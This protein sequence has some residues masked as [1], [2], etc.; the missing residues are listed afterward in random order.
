MQFH[1][2]EI[3]LLYNPETSTGRQTRAIAKTINSNVNELNVLREKLGPTYWKEVVNLLGLEPKEMMDRSHPDYQNLVAGKSFTM[4]GYLD[5]L[6]HFPH[7]IKGPIVIFNGRAVLCQTPTDI[8]KLGVRTSTDDLGDKVLP[9][10]RN[11][12]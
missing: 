6:I 1:P 3:F 11:T 10:L 8:F 5:V 9:H 7:L 2:N 12:F 4:N